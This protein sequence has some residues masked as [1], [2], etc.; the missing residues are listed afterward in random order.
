MANGIDRNSANKWILGAV[1]AIAM[2]LFGIWTAG[3]DKAIDSNRIDIKGNTAT[4][5][6]VDAKIRERLSKIETQLDFII[7]KQWGSDE[8]D[9][10]E[11]SRRSHDTDRSDRQ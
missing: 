4:I 2:T 5:N 11:R 3:L 8:Y 7:T 6:T 1:F 9:R 10:Y